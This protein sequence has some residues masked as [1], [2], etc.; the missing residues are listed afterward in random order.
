MTAKPPLL[1]DYQ[2]PAELAAE[3]NVCTKTL[4]RWRADRLG[5][6]I[7]KIGRRVLYR[8]SAVAAWLAAQES[9]A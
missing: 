8:R 6:K 2:T 3:L 4:E 9:A 7:T 1:D 5:P